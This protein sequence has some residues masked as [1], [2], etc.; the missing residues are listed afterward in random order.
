MTTRD[1]WDR[2]SEL[3]EGVQRAIEDLDELFANTGVTLAYLFGSLGQGR[4]ARDVDLAV[5]AGAK[6]VFELRQPICDRLGTERLDLVDL[7]AAPP[8]LRFE[9][10]RTGRPIYAADE[11]V[12]NRFELETIHLY[13]D[14]RHQRQVQARYLRERMAE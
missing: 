8:E 14:T 9:I 1:R 12:L 6:P 2:F 10:V 3:P 7:A 13:R 11:D 4:S 5:L